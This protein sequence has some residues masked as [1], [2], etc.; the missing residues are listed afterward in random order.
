MKAMEDGLK[1]EGF[2][3]LGWRNVPVEHSVVGEVA[4]ATE[5]RISQVVVRDSKGRSG[6]ELERFLYL[7]RKAVERKRLAL[8]PSAEA[9]YICSLSCQVHSRPT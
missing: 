4:K 1:S 8:G 7:G 9:F 3:I 6:P 5:P 2:E